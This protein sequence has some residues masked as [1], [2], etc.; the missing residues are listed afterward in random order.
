[1]AKIKLFCDCGKPL[2]LG[3]SAVST[4][5]LKFEKC[6]Y[7]LNTPRKYSTEHTHS[8]VSG[9][10]YDLVR[11]SRFEFCCDAYDHEIAKGEH[12]FESKSRKRLCFFCGIA[13]D[14][15]NYAP[16]QNREEGGSRQNSKASALKDW[17]SEVDAAIQNGDL[18]KL[19]SLQLSKP[20]K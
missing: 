1:M 10:R 5:S 7:C 4:D 13:L 11:G 3:N 17:Q 9:I 19:L 14:E 8:F 6:R 16:Y 12:Y 2:A 18:K 15:T 20:K